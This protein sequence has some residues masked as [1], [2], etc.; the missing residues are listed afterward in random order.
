[1]GPVA[2]VCAF[3]TSSA[4]AQRWHRFPPQRMLAAWQRRWQHARR[5]G[6]HCASHGCGTHG[7]G[8]CGW[9]ASTMGSRAAVER[10]MAGCEGAGEE[11]REGQGEHGGSGSGAESMGAGRETGAGHDALVPLPHS[12]HARQG[13]SVALSVD[14]SVGFDGIGACT[15]QAQASS[16]APD[17]AAKAATCALSAS[18]SPG[19]LELLLLL[20]YSSSPLHPRLLAGGACRGRHDGAVGLGGR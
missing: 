13:V 17:A 4:C 15:R 7:R 14:D 18:S 11:E 5:G 19:V 3:S 20:A 2:P 16:R 1:M 8:T 9:A 10:V 6:G 12:A